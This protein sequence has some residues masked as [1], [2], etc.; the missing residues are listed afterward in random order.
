[1]QN[2]P[3]KR[4]AV[5]RR[6][7]HCVVVAVLLC[8]LTGIS[9]SV[10]G[11][12]YKLESG[13]LA[14]RAAEACDASGAST[15][16]ARAIARDSGDRN[17]LADQVIA[18]QNASE[19]TAMLIIVASYLVIIPS[20]LFS[21]R[22]T[23]VFLLNTRQKIMKKLQMHTRATDGGDQPSAAAANA[24]AQEMI[25]LTIHA[26]DG[27]RKRL[28][29]I[30]AL[31][32]LTFQPR[33]VY[34]VIQAIGNTS[35]EWNSSCGVCGACQSVYLLVNLWLRS[36]APF[37]QCFFVTSRQVH[38]SISRHRRH[39]QLAAAPVRVSVVHDVFEAETAACNSRRIGAGRPERR[40]KGGG[41]CASRYAYRPAC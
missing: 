15:A 28:V 21:L 14:L 30:N 3:P 32:F 18:V 7:F 31:I 35:T 12:Y 11:S 27:Q 10:A 16:A 26:A 34:A 19:M 13:S 8:G 4:R 33:A 2:V 25:D 40:G 22:I 6:A 23:K 5:I 36:V 9:A 1:M 38:A 17:K 39:D 29:V 37:L 20:C 24:K 41:V